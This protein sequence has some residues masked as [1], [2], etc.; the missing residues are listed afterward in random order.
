MLSI[1]ELI[2]S[3]KE[4]VESTSINVLMIAVPLAM[5]FLAGVSTAIA[6]AVERVIT[7]SSRH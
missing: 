3:A 4:M 2:H 7:G 6:I 1:V 5:V